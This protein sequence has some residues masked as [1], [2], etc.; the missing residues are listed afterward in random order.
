MTIQKDLLMN[1]VDRYKTQIYMYNSPINND[2]G[3]ATGGAKNR[4]NLVDTSKDIFGRYAIAGENITDLKTRSFLKKLASKVKHIT[5]IT[6]EI[7]GQTLKLNKNSAI[8]RLG[9]DKTALKTAMK[10]DKKNGNH[11]AVSTLV[12]NAKKKIEAELNEIPFD[13]ECLEKIPL[14]KVE[15]LGAHNADLNLEARWRYNQQHWSLERQL[16][17][18]VRAFELDI[19]TDSKGAVVVC[20][21]RARKLDP[22]KEG[23]YVTG[24]EKLTEIKEWLKKHPKEVLIIKLDNGR[25]AV[26][27]GGKGKMNTVDHLFK[28]DK[29]LAE[30]LLTPKD[31]AKRKDGGWPTVGE[32]RK[33][34]KR[35]VFINSII[36]VTKNETSKYT[37]Y[38]GD[39]M[40]ETNS[41][42]L[43]TALPDRK[44]LMVNDPNIK[45]EPYMVRNGLK[46]ETSGDIAHK[47]RALEKKLAIM[48]HVSIIS[49][50]SLA[51]IFRA[52]G[53]STK[54]LFRVN[55]DRLT[56]PTNSPNE[57]DT[58]AEKVKNSDEKIHKRPNAAWLDFTD[59]YILQGGIKGINERNKETAMLFNRKV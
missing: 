21:G 7:D 34:K 28:E 15:F 46:E 4:I 37:H 29:E 54:L 59:Q 50:E 45:P 49:N 39:V 8:V 19:G 3:I 12:I 31:L 13:S 43:N 22:L 36:P 25:D 35:A 17:A 41:L 33:L 52:F 38:V 1:N 6:V 57:I 16:N 47:E 42:F 10:S 40:R 24:K 30:L 20:H 48:P 9:I 55:P 53:R 58:L 23:G 11:Q 14:D 2:K 18:G 26:D 5:S 44:M 51:K 27:R 32:M 56:L